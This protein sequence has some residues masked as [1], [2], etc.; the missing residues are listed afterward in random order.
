MRSVF[1]IKS[2]VAA[3]ALAGCF[4]LGTP[5]ASAGSYCHVSPPPPVQC[6][7]KTVVVYEYARKPFY[8]YVIRYDHCGEPYRAKVVVWRTVK[9][10]VTKQVRVC[11]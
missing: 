11:H 10:P 6:Y 2:L 9:V 3:V 5:S 4:S 8:D 7:Y 1:S